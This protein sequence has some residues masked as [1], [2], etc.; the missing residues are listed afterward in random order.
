MSYALIDNASLTA[1]QRFLGKITITNTDTINGDLVALENFLQAILFY[2]ELICIDNYKPEFREERKKVFDFIRF[3]SEEDYNLAEIDKLAKEEARQINPEIRGGEFVNED[4]KSLIEQLKLNIVCTWDLASSVFYLTLK[5]LGQPS[6]PEFTKYSEISA[7]IFS[8]LSDLTGTQKGYWSKDVRIIGADGHEYS[9]NDFMTAREK[10]NRGEG[11]LS[12][13]LS[14]FIASLNW[15]SYKSI[16]YSL[17]AQHLKADTF[18]HPLRHAYQIQWMKKTGSFGHEFT[19]RLIHN[20]N[21][22]I[23][24]TTSDI[25]SHGHSDTFSLELPIFSAWIINQCDGN[26]NQVISTALEL[27]NSSLFTEVRG[28]LRQ[29]HKAYD[30]DGIAS[31]NTKVTKLLSDLEQVCGNI[32]RSYGLPTTQGI[33]TSFL[34][35]CVNCVTAVKLGITLPEVERTIPVPKFLQNHNQKVFS[36]VFKDLTHELTNTERLGSLRTQL[37]SSFVIDDRFYSAPKVEKPEFR[38]FESDWKKPMY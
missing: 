31:G 35:K 1:V 9:N 13:G 26:T 8:E 30:E 29:I 6:S 22:Q 24:T 23:K 17:A 12:N 16:Y 11:G 25:I 21:N 3:L 5:M 15:L 28:I 14:T 34:I 2:D 32:K 4:F 27:K 36:N 10:Q 18:I 38:W 33:N 19:S 20:L 7:S 37:G